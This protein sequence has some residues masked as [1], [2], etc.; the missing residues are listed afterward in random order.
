MRR[1]R[2][3]TASIGIVVALLSSAVTVA[4][5]NDSPATTTPATGSATPTAGT[6]EP[7]SPTTTADAPTS[8]S[9]VEA[10]PTQPTPPSTTSRAVRR[11]TYT[12]TPLWVYGHSYTTHPGT[13]NTRGQEWMPELASGLGSPRWHTFGVGSSRLIDTFGDLS[14]QAPKAAVADSAWTSAR[15]GAV[16]LQ[17]EFNDTLNPALGGAN[18]AVRLSSLAASN[19]EQTLQASLAV[20]SSSSRLDWSTSTA[21][22]GWVSS[23]GS[24]YLGGS[25]TYTITPGAYREMAV[26]VGPSGTTWVL[27][28]EASQALRNPHTG[29]TAISV[30]GRQ[31]MQIPRR[32]SSWEPIWSRRGGYQHNV[33]PRVTKLSGL[34][35]GRHV[36]R[37][38]K[39]DQGPGAVYLD[40]VLV[41]GTE[42]LPV[43][44]VK[45]PP[46]LATGT[47]WVPNYMPVLADNRNL[48]HA[49]I[50]SVVAQFPNAAWVSLSGILPEHFG[51]DG[52]HLSDGG[53]D[54]ERRLLDGA[55][56]RH[57]RAYNVDAMYE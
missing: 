45:D 24:A 35:P 42:P 16:I 20:L 55:F 31:R 51:A 36:I 7:S 3:A 9:T 22:R 18:R 47:S 48:L 56:R 25:L 29:V 5:A 49:R 44:V 17:S 21:S 14:R 32:T 13:V 28:W 12:R 43:L 26:N 15:R 2:L 50:D 53:M 23:P 40:Q 52:V 37:V 33:G 41:Q 11:A 46:P 39:A 57:V 27:T 19:F 30:D 54:Y 6:T 4:G 10:P 1:G 8:S 34:T 38:T